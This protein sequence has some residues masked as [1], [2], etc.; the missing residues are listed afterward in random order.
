[1]PLREAV[2][3][4]RAEIIEASKAS[5]DEVVKFEIGTIEI[6]LTVLAKREGGLD[7]KISFSVLGPVP[8]WVEVANFQR[9]KLIRS[10]CS[11]RRLRFCLMEREDI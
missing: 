8:N 1:M 11:S 5:S 6:E 7:G 2:Q 10:N 4:L 3:A 9:S